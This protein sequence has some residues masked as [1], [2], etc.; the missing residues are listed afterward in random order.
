MGTDKEWRHK[1]VSSF[2]EEKFA[3]YKFM[4]VNLLEIGTGHGG[5]L[6]L[7]NDYFQDGNIIGVDVCDLTD[8]VI[9][10]YPRIRRYLTDGYSSVFSNILPPLDIVIDDGP[11]T[12]PSFVACIEQYLPKINTGGVLVIEDIPDIKHTDV[13]KQ[14]VSEYKHEVI[15]TRELSGLHDNIMFVIWK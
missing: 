11:H 2:Y 7:W 5:S 10:A 1:Y 13:L 4:P 6:I 9:G 8:P 15:D 3:C 12:L 14:M